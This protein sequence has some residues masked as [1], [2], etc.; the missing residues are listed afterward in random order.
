MHM[1]VMCTSTCV[2]SGKPSLLNVL[3]NTKYL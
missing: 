2:P 1:H 3:I